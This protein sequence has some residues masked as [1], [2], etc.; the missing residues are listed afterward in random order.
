M[1]LT[2]S[3]I[4][5][6]FFST[7]FHTFTQVVPVDGSAPVN[8]EAQLRLMDILAEVTVTAEMSG[9]A[10]SGAATNFV[11][12]RRTRIHKSPD[13]HETGWAFSIIKD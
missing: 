4:D 8:G 11:Q 5:L 7:L 3:G 12:V 13:R 2:L 6:S 1:A 10:K 9:L